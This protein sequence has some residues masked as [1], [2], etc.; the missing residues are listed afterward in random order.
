MLNLIRKAGQ[1]VSDADIAYSN[2]VFDLIAKHAPE[3]LK[4]PLMM[5]STASLFQTRA[6]TTGLSRMEALRDNAIAAGLVGTSALARYGLPAGGITLAGKGL[7]DL[8]AA[9]GNGAD[10]PEPGQLPLS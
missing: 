1:Y 5:T 2:A 10:Y 9:F 8:T 7:Y 4:A 6:D 3:N